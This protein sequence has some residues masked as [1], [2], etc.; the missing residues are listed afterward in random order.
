MKKSLGKSGSLPTMFFVVAG[1]VVLGVTSFMLSQVGTDFY[2]P[3]SKAG[4]PCG[5]VGA[6][7]RSPITGGYSTCYNGGDPPAA[8]QVNCCESGKVLNATYQC[9]A[10]SPV[11]QYGTTYSADT[12][13]SY[14]ICGESVDKCRSERVQ[15]A[16]TTLCR[17][18]N[19]EAGTEKIYD[20]C[21]QDGSV[22]GTTGNFSCSTSAPTAT[23]PPAGTT[24]PPNPTST[25]TSTPKPTGIFCKDFSKDYPNRTCNNA[26]CSGTKDTC[27]RQLLTDAKQKYCIVRTSVERVYSCCAAGKKIVDGACVS[28]TP[29]PTPTL[30][31]SGTPT[32]SP[33]ITTTVTDTPTNTP[34]ITTGTPTVTTGTPTVTTGTPTTTKTPSA[35]HSPSET[36]FA[37]EPLLYIGAILYAVG[38]VSFVAARYY[39]ATQRKIRG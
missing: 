18:K 21:A 1:L 9:V 32:P 22:V 37:D 33:T 5:Q 28:S 19:T 2:E 10:P 27:A 24:Q 38:V 25:S 15:Y 34:T 11:C 12:C 29:T 6:C 8:P 35:T 31:S 3:V 14:K 13:I 20:C 4:G 23:T 7:T 30:T 17:K 16:V 36:G 39:G 26:I